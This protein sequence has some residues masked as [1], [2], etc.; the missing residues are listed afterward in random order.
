MTDCVGCARM[1][2]PPWAPL[3]EGSCQPRLRR[4]RT[5]RRGRRAKA[6]I[7]ARSTHGTAHSC[8]SAPDLAPA[9]PDPRSHSGFPQCL[10]RG[11]ATGLPGPARPVPPREHT[12]DRN[13]GSDGAASAAGAAMCPGTLPRTIDNARVS[14]EAGGKPA[15]TRNREPHVALEAGRVRRAGTPSAVSTV[16][17]S[18]T[19]VDRGTEAILMSAASRPSHHL[20]RA[21]RAA[22]RRRVPAT[23]C[24]SPRPAPTGTRARA[25]ATAV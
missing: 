9:S 23:P 10:D 15:L 5:R 20:D 4:L 24:R 7:L 2:S 8:G 12:H 18:N 21:V 16:T 17:P 19:V 11:S 14:G 22:R 3:L 6:G 1:T 13:D 25:S